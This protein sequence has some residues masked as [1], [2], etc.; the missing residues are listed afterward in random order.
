MALF[1]TQEITTENTEKIRVRQLDEVLSF[2]L[3]RPCLT[4]CKKWE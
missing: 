3:F 2:R 1:T 4:A